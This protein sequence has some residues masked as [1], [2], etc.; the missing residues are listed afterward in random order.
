[1][2][3]DL[4]GGDLLGGG[5]V[6]LA[7]LDR[8]DDL[9][10]VGALAVETTLGERLVP[11]QGAFERRPAVELVVLELRLHVQHEL[12]AEVL[13]LG[14][15]LP[16]SLGQLLELALALLEGGH[17][18]HDAAKHELAA[19]A[20]LHLL[21]KLLDHLLRLLLEAL[22]I[23]LGQFGAAGAPHGN[24]HLG[25]AVA[26]GHDVDV[27][28]HDAAAGAGAG[29]DL[30]GHH[31]GTVPAVEVPLADNVI[32]E[33]DAVAGLARVL[34]VGVDL[35]HRVM[36]AEFHD[37][38]PALRQELD[39][40][41]LERREVVLE[42]ILDDRLLRLG[43]RELLVEDGQIA[44]NEVGLAQRAD[45]GHRDVEDVGALALVDDH[46]PVAGLSM[47]GGGQEEAA[48]AERCEE[49]V[50]SRHWW[51]PF[52]LNETRAGGCARRSGR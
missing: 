31:S 50:R 47:G 51:I 28:T 24:R 19:V 40:E 25:P 38:R 20:L 45:I 43:Q 10:E 42:Q 26:A 29:F 49:V 4:V 23:F 44:A 39:G 15:E 13:L 17:V 14:L 32:G 5:S 35:E 3:H 22:A 34:V 16:G 8:L 1:M 48:H 33:E 46:R 12:V 21:A 2:H 27:L 18:R 37:H 30:D 11:G 6:E 36:I 52:T 7:R 41:Q 9:D